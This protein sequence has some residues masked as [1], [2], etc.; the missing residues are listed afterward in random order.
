M[1]RKIHWIAIAGLCLA[2][3]GGDD[4]DNGAISLIRIT[5]E[6]AGDN[7]PAGGNKVDT[8]VDDD[9]DG[10]L[11]DGEVDSTSFLCDGADG[12]NGDDGSDGNDGTNGNDGSDGAI[13]LVRIEDEPSGANCPFGGKVVHTGVDAN[14]DGLLAAEEVTDTA[15]ICNDGKSP[16]VPAGFRLLSR[17]TTIPSAE[18]IAADPDGQTL[19]YTTGTTFAIGFVDV[20][21]PA[22]PEFLVEVSVAD[23]VANAGAGEPTSVAITPNGQYAIAAV[24]DTTD[25][26][27][28]EDPGALVFIDMESLEIAGTVTLGIGPDSVAITPDGSQVIVAIEDE[29]D[30]DLAADAQARPGSLQ[31]ITIDYGAPGSSAVVTVPLTPDV[32]NN[33]SDPQPEYV[34]I[35]D[36]G[37]LAVVTLQENN[38][39]ALVDLTVSPVAV[40]YIDAGLVERDFADIEED[41][42]VIFAPVAFAGR[43]EPDGVCLL[44]DGSAFVTA[45]EGDTGFD[46][47]GLG[48]FSGGRG[49]TIFDTDGDVLFEVGGE[50]EQLAL[51]F[52]AY[53]DGRSGNRGIEVEGCHTANFSGREYAFLLGE[54]NSTVAVYDVS[55]PV[56]SAFVQL[57]PSPLRPESATSSVKRGLLFVAGEGDDGLGGGIWIYGAVGDSADV[58][59]LAPGVFQA[60]SA[61]QPAQPFGGLSSV[62]FDAF[63]GQFVAIADNA[64]AQQR[65]WRFEPVAA[66]SRMRLVDELPLTETDGL[67]PIVGYDP[68][69]ISLLR[70][71]GYVVA[72]E[73]REDNGCDAPDD[74]PEILR[75][76]LLFFD[77]DGVLDSR[78]GTDGAVDLP[79]E[80][81]PRLPRFGFE[82]V[83]VV[84]DPDSGGLK[85]YVAFQR[86]LDSLDENDPDPEELLH[87][88]RIGEYDVDS[89]TWRFFFYPLNS[90]R[91]DVDDDRILIS[92]IRHLGGDAFA[93]I[94]RDEQQ[95]ATATIKRVYTVE[96]STGT[97]DDVSDP[98]EKELWIDLLKLP[99]AADFAKIEGLALDGDSLWVTN[100][101]DGGESSNFFIEVP[102]ASRAPV[103]TVRFASFNTSLNR[104]NQGDLADEFQDGSSAHGQA[105]AEILQRV[106]P[107][108]VLLNEFDFDP[109]QPDVAIN[110]FQQNY[111]EVG[112]N[113]AASI[114]YPF[115]FVAPSNTGVHS[116]FDLDNQNGVVDTVG[117]NGYGNDAFGFGNFPGQFAMVL[118][119][120][121]PIATDDV[122]TF[123][124]FL[125]RDMP[126]ALLPDDAGTPE[127]NDFYSAE[128]L[129]VFRLSSKSHWD[130]PIVVGNRVIHVLANHPTPPVFDGEE[131]R[132]GRRNH[133]EI[134]FWADYVAP[135]VGDYIVD[136]DGVRGGIKAGAAFVIMGDQNA[137]PFDGDS[138]DNAILQLLDSP[139]VNGA[140]PPSSFGGIEQARL[141]GGLN[142]D[143]NGNAAVDTADFGDEGPFGSGNLRVDYVL[144]SHNL[145]IIG[146]GAFWPA[147]DSALFPLVSF[148]DHRLVFSDIAR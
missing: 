15:Y 22:R 23:T 87:L 17:L 147:A 136:D 29:E 81:W 2:A 24:K 139:Q 20:S 75:N 127:A 123:Q 16:N 67:T 77:T 62:D 117:E 114:E 44:S 10:S 56:S 93:L 76:R 145:D 133:D 144:P 108:V 107:D 26:V 79:E 66:S 105:I 11:A 58:G 42:E 38:A 27:D 64:F 68:E 65:I 103:P 128:E 72:T 50:L 40:R 63:A 52:G 6:P 115:V 28:N 89:D 21:D 83:T 101:N 100:D 106:R 37:T 51:Q 137:D 112:Q 125:W 59:S 31:I 8:G 88:T 54:R 14:G 36:D 49:F 32:G 85:A 9:G 131:D 146:S 98:L 92:E 102:L 80:L 96:L 95:A 46:D 90:D 126:G 142:V 47:F 132:N 57:L 4:G 73:G 110:L 116:G 113:G 30:T 71:G 41:D 86:P 34:D 134:R 141:Q 33:P 53:P 45:N 122:R 120:R 138:T 1:F 70:D 3:C 12:S 118:L 19:A 48:Q 119:S 143:H 130:V 13:S 39:I 78:F 82:G 148:P 18:I 135:G 25:P 43:R 140:N 121:F 74:C 111:L 5:P 60:V 129:D 91:S 109:G 35:S 99:F 7:C 124:N 84:E 104:E 55:A 61:L 94:E 97:A 69:G